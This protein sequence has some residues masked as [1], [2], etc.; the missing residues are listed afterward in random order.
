MNGGGSK[1]SAIPTARTIV[2][3]AKAADLFIRSIVNRYEI[4]LLILDI[5]CSI[6]VS[7]FC[8]NNNFNSSQSISLI[9]NFTQGTI[10]KLLRSALILIANA[11]PKATVFLN[12]NDISDT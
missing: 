10:P 11:K 9:A 6:P 5:L 7:A 2:Y 4:H 8:Y 3:Q 1:H 12:I